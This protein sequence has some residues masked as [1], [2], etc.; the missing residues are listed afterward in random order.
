MGGVVLRGRPFNTGRGGR[1]VDSLW[2][3]LKKNNFLT[4]LKKKIV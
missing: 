4:K 1:G 2:F 3:F